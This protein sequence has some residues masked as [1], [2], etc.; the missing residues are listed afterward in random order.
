MN[1]AV[2]NIRRLEILSA[3][4]R[5]LVRRCEQLSHE[6]E[7]LLDQVYLRRADALQAA[8]RLSRHYLDFLSAEKRKA[9]VCSW[10]A[11]LECA[12]LNHAARQQASGAGVE[13]DKR[14]AFHL[15]GERPVK[16][17][18]FSTC[19][20]A[21]RR[22]TRRLERDGLSQTLLRIQGEWYC[23]WTRTSD[24]ATV[25]TGSG[26][27]PAMAVCRAVLNLDLGRL[28]PAILSD[29]PSKAGEFLRA[30]ALETFRCAECGAEIASSRKP[31][32]GTTCNPCAWRAGRG[33][34]LAVRP[35]P[36]LD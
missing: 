3:D 11:V 32:A 5:S 8:E 26:P 27:A 35:A 13:L 23:S 19:L 12:R 18:P 24:G 7:I 17:P 16:A 21:S 14:V 29:E 1:Q 9:C 36:E 6:S 28:R 33:R 2:A 34:R 15:A 31:R 4:L 10:R 30:R 22:L 20:S 25:A